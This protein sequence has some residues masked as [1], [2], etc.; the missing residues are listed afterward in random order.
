MIDLGS[1]NIEENALTNIIVLVRFEVLVIYRQIVAKLSWSS[2]MAI[3]YSMQKFK[4]WKC[5]W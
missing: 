4:K 2:K 5:N 1:L 3:E